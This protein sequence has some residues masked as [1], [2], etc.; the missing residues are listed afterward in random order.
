MD[1][2]RARRRIGLG[3]SLGA[4]CAIACNPF[5]DL[6]KF[7]LTGEQTVSIPGKNIVSDPLS[8]V[9]VPDIGDSLSQSMS[10]TFE[11]QG[12]DK[13]DVDSFVPKQV[14]IEIVAPTPM[15]RDGHFMQDLRFFDQITFKVSADGVGEAVVAQSAPGAFAVGVTRYEF[16]VDSAQNLKSYVVASAM[17][18]TV[19]ATASDRPALGCDVHFAAIFTVDVNPGG[20][21]Q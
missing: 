18:L 15:D 14:L 4:L 5:A 11:N 6:E 2:R 12:V 16:P 19:D 3:S 9:A 20:A 8:V 21:L 7:D 13:N 17:T 1:S 10:Q